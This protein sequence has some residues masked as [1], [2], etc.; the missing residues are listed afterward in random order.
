MHEYS[1]ISQLQLT[2]LEN[3]QQV[4]QSITIKNYLHRKS[5]HRIYIMT[6]RVMAYESTIADEG[7]PKWKVALAVG[8]PVALGVAG[9]W[10]YRRHVSSSSAVKSKSCESMS[11][12]DTT[13]IPQACF[14]IMAHVFPRGANDSDFHQIHQC[15][16]CMRHHWLEQA[17]A[18]LDIPEFIDHVPHPDVSK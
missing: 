6:N 8:A 18:F 13:Q 2:L 14:A 3:E 11:V 17:Q 1:K 16:Q 10:F 7:W 4:T 12:E 9:V 5:T 15:C